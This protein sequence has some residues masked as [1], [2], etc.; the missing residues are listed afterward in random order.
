MR[1]PELRTC[2]TVSATPVEFPAH[3]GPSGYCQGGRLGSK[4]RTLAYK[5]EG[6]DNF[7][8]AFLIY[9]GRSLDNYCVTV[10]ARVVVG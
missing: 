7:V 4:G 10:S 2:L 9:F 6:P 1:L 5:T 8:R 3:L